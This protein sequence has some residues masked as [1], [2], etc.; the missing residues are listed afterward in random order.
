V[1]IVIAT[2]ATRRSLMDRLLLDGMDFTD[3]NP[4]FGAIGLVVTL[5]VGCVLDGWL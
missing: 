3:A 1:E 4:W 5:V 2:H